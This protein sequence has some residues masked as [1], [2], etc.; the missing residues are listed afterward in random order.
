VDSFLVVVVGAF[1]VV[2]VALGKLVLDETDEWSTD[3]G[4]TSPVIFPGMS[5]LSSL[6]CRT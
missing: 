4:I 3:E 6:S 2:L 5:T 1:V